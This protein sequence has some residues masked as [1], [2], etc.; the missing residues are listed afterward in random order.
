MS[1]LH[2][3]LRCMTSMQRIA[4]IAQCQHALL[5]TAQARGAGI[6][7]HDLERL[8]ERG[9]LV[10]VRR[11]VH[12][13]AGAPAT[14]EQA[15][16]AA[17]L[18]S[19][20]RALASHSTAAW[21]HGFEGERGA[22]L[23]VMTPRASRARQAG[24][25]Q[26]RG[27]ALTADATTRVQIPTTSAARTVVD[28]SARCDAVRLGRL[29]DD[30]LR[31]GILS[32]GGLKVCVARLYRG[33]G[34]RPSVV[35]EVLRKRL[36]GYEPGDSDFESH[37]HDL[38]EEAGVAGFVRQHRV[39]LGGRRY[40]LD[41]AQPELQIDVETDGWDSHRTRSAFDGDR[42]R[43]NALVAAGWTVLRFTWSMSDD[44]IVRAVRATCDRLS[45]AA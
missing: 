29:V 45:A 24:V 31:R 5:T 35:H 23:E 39:R 38:L 30:G 26:H 25:I 16:L 21:L 19:G 14:R 8:R 4:R 41:L 2:V 44:E 11:G 1:H 20:S 36:P 10:T 17:V 13:I 37:V 42:A 32:L 12:A 6:A 7:R 33:P 43:S 9:Y 40:A 3:R 22:A 28:L 27:A 18:A 15:I 34:R